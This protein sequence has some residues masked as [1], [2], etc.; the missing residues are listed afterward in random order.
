MRRLLIICIV[1]LAA[2]SL[3]SQATARIEELDSVMLDTK[4]KIPRKNSGKVITTI[5]QETLAKNSGKSVAQLLNEVS[6]IEINGGR[7][8]DGINLGYYIRGGRN[9]QVVIMIDGVQVTDPS[10]ISNDYDLRLIPAT[11]IENIEIIKGAS[12]VL[13]GSGAAAAVINITTKMASTKPISGTFSSTFGSNR[14]SEE[15]G[16]YSINEFTNF[17]GMNG[18]LKKFFY[19]LSFGNRYVDGLSAVAAP[20]GEEGFEEDIFN[21]FNGRINLGY[22]FNKDVSMNQFFSFDNFKTDFDNFNYT[23]AENRSITK[24]LRTGGHFEWKYS[25]GIY[26]FNDSF[27]WIEREINSDFPSKYDADAYSLDNYITYNFSKQFTAL[28]GLNYMNSSF[29]SFS[30]PFGGN[31]FEQNINEDSAKFN[32]V[33]P[34]LNLTYISTFGLNLNTGLRLNIHSNYGNH[35][36]Y[37]VNP[38]YV[39]SFGKNN[40]KVLGSYSTAYITPSLF[41]L[42][43]PLYGNEELQ[44]EKNR[45]IEG[46]VEISIE[47]DFRVSA[48]YFNRNEENFVDF[49]NIDP[50]NFIFQYQNLSEAF[51]ASGVEVEISNQ[52]GKKLN[53]SANYT[54]TQADERFAL[55]IP[56]HKVNANIGYQISEKS[57]IGASYQYNSE[58]EDSFFNPNTFETE[59]VTLESYGLLD[60]TASHR[61]STNLKIFAN[62][63]NL[64]NEEYEEIYRFQTRGR[65]LR[66]GFTLDF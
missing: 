26:V 56:E 3:F 61:I 6:G 10:S 41:Q 38:S 21:R 35:L 8:N 40:L 32:I 31:N 29:N 4:I 37:N 42:Y 20:E 11:S 49:V 15:E 23:D 60:I 5:S 2:N 17:V 52:F 57:F 39:F 53:L 44:P 66:F 47:G 46:G 30:I 51:N 58:R 13:Y 33:D 59:N 64:M 1:F 9:R 50:D 48:V 14:P 18:T 54:N 34:Y 45:T 22:R 24:Q 65:N 16:D 12:S 28:L 43:D 36:V 7:S 25:K 27:T 19:D 63:S 55:R 62:V